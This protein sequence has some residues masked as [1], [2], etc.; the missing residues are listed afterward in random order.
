[1]GGRSQSSIPSSVIYSEAGTAACCPG[2]IKMMTQHVSACAAP[3][4]L[5]YYDTT[6]FFTLTLCFR[7]TQG[8][9]LADD[10]ERPAITEER[11]S[12]ERT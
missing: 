11:A 5:D 7:P 9:A 4:G 3:L 6:T 2:Q 8:H 12:E 10:E 1:M